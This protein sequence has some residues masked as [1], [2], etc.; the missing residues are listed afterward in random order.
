MLKIISGTK[1]GTVLIP[2]KGRDVRPTPARVREAV[3]SMIGEAVVD[4]DVID[5]F[6]GSGALGIEALS[7]VARSAYFV[8]SSADAISTIRSNLKK[9]DFEHNA[10]TLQADFKLALSR[11]R[12]KHM[13]FDLVLLD[14]PYADGILEPAMQMIVEYD[15]LKEGCLIV[16]EYAAPAEL[17][18][19]EELHLSNNKRYGSTGIDIF[20]RQ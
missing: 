15:L 2:F 10:Q 8:D 5:L 11:F 7:R 17:K 13:R 19:P 4:A 16:A 18:G 1:K 3:F 12:R 14:P 6:A 9:A 20:V